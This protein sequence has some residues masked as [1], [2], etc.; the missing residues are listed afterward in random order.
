[1]NS[2]RPDQTQEKVTEKDVPDK[3]LSIAAMVL[4][5]LSLVTDFVANIVLAIISLCFVAK[6]KK[7]A[8]DRKL[9]G[10]ATAG[11]IC[12]IVALSCFVLEVL[13]TI[14]FFSIFGEAWM[15]SLEELSHYL[16][17]FLMF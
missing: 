1:M 14:V 17:D 13:A 12:S 16:N 6:I 11:M 7:S 15:E 2:E 5:I 10:F 9:N 4:G 3:K 8:A